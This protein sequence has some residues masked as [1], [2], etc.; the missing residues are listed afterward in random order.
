MARYPVAGR[1]KT[2]LVPALGAQ[3]AAALYAAFLADLGRRLSRLRTG[4]YWAYTPAAAPFAR[5]GLPGEA[6]PQASGDLGR[7][8]YCVFQRLF[9]AGHSLVVVIGSDSPHLPVAYLVRAVERLGKADVVLG[10][11]D[12]GGYYL[13]GMRALNDLFH[14]IPWSTGT[15]LAETLRRAEATGLRVELLP[16]TFDVDEPADLPRLERAVRRRREDLRATR[17]VLA[18]MWRR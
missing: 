9:A 10:P 1:T 14:G 13:V 7:R 6:F 17:E 18:R 16:R 12:D 2:R 8:L 15:V 3:G 5:L 11:A 4:L